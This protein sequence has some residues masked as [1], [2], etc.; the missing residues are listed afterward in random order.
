LRRKTKEK[1]HYDDKSNNIMK[2]Y[3]NEEKK[4]KRDLNNSENFIGKHSS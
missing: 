2:N 3:T 4:I 1:N